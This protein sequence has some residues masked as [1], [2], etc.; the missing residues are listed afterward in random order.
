M[1][2]RA[3]LAAQLQQPA[4]QFLNLNG[5]P[6]IVAPGAHRAGDKADEHDEVLSPPPAPRASHGTPSQE[7]AM[8]VATPGGTQSP[9]PSSVPLLDVSPA[10]AS[11]E[12]TERRGS[13]AP[14]SAH[15]LRERTLSAQFG[16]LDPFS[17]VSYTHLTLPTKA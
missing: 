16:E 14:P 13:P 10:P 12:P 4:S 11:E 7:S 1:Q 3:Q 2:H 9:A 8:L 15:A 6:N 17:P 5:R